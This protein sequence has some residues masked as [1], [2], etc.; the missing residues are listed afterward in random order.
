MHGFQIT[1]YFEENQRHHRQ[2]L[3]EWLMELA[4]ELQLH[5]A[6]LQAAMEGF[7]R[8]GNIHAAH[9]IELADRPLQF[10]TVV[11]TEEADRLLA[12]LQ[13]EGVSLFYVKAAV[14]FGA[15]P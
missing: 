1:F 8:S 12:R 11:T 3:G 13:T 5:G 10:V 4:R 6:T 15:L 14:E 7:G 9:F 2:P